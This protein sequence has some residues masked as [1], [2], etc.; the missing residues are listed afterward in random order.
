MGSRPVFEA[1]ANT[2]N[3]A[4][5]MTR[6][7]C[8]ANWAAAVLADPASLA[9]AKSVHALSLAIALKRTKV[10][11]STLLTSGSVE[12]FSAIANTG[13]QAISDLVALSRA[14]GNTAC[15]T[16]PPTK[17][18]T[19]SVNFAKSVIVTIL[20]AHSGAAVASSPIV[21][22]LANSLNALSVVAAQMHALERGLG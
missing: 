17:A 15:F 13:H 3:S 2:G 5:S 14:M 6:A 20:L 7:A 9:L 8:R 18:A 1:I 16:F 19:K 22:T 11:A 21:I 4:R 10:F 12:G